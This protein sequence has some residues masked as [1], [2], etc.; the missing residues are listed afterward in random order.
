MTNTR[1]RSALAAITAALAMVV[2]SAAAASAAPANATRQSGGAAGVVAAVVQVDDA[3]NNLS[4]LSDIGSVEVITV[5]D[6]LNNVLQNATFLNNVTVLQ[7]F[8]NNND[9]DV[10]ND[11]LNNNNVVITDVIAIEVLSGGDLVIFTQ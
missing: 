10:L 7:N 6:S 4:V 11:A 9:V 1:T 2:T 3:L 5:K 8:L